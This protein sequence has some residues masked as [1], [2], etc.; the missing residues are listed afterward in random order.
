M[1]KM[2]ENF[3]FVAPLFLKVLA[4]TLTLVLIGFAIA[5]KVYGEITRVDIFGSLIS[6]VVFSYMVHLWLMPSEED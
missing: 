2:K 6:A 5:L 1:S 3:P 4:A